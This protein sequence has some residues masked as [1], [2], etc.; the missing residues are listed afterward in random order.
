MDPGIFRECSDI[1]CQFRYPAIR[2]INELVDNCPKCGKPAFIVEKVFYGRENIEE[3]IF[4]PAGFEIIP[5]LDNIR[6]VYNVGSIFR[7]ANGF[8]VR[9]IFLGGITSTPIH[10]QFDKTSLGAD[11]AISWDHAN[12]SN[13]IIEELK[14]NDFQIISLENAAQ[15]IP[16]DKL[17]IKVLKNK[18]ALVVG[19][20][21]LGIDPKIV[22]R[23]DLLVSIP[24][25]GTKKSFNVCVAFG[26][27]LYQLI[28]VLDS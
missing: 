26:I 20:E 22:R 12:N 5:V 15:S 19:N 24:M 21:K 2:N 11:H 18:I 17:D 7:S 8:G 9:Q 23:S 10:S 25:R 16:V 27:A 3:I 13:G 1:T 4:P 6:S 14:N 28:K